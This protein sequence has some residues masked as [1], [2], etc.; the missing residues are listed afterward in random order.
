M[1]VL[2]L[3]EENKYALRMLGGGCATSAGAP[4]Y[5]ERSGAGT[6]GRGGSAHRIGRR[7]NASPDR[8]VASPAAQSD[9]ID[10]R[11]VTGLPAMSAALLEVKQK[12]EE[13]A[14]K[15]SFGS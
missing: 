9:R 7:R 11:I 2:N 3:F 4:L 5:A 13:I 14:K 8:R 12:D 15:D 1:Y 10:L 6:V